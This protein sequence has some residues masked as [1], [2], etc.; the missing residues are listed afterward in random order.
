[1]YVLVPYNLSEI[2]KGIQAAHAIAEYVYNFKREQIT[3]DWVNTDKTIVILNGGT[4]N[5]SSDM[6]KIGSLQKHILNLR[7]LKVTHTVFIEPDLNNSETA[8][9]F[10]VDMEEDSHVVGYLKQMGL[11]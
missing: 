2:Q 11:A 9:A 7:K 1:M 6:N 5:S 10:I 3:C 8:V 4:T